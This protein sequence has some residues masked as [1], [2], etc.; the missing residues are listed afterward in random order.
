MTEKLKIFNPDGTVTEVTPL[1]LWTPD[2]TSYVCL[3]CKEPVYRHKTEWACD[4]KSVDGYYDDL[5][6][7]HLDGWW[8]CWVLHGEI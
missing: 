4:C 5:S 3:D 2:E 1:K 7:F 8:D 6:E